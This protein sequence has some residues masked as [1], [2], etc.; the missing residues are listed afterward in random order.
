MLFAGTLYSDGGIYRKAKEDLSK[1]FGPLALESAPFRWEHSD[2]YEQELG[3]PLTRRFIFFERAIPPDALA[4][5]KLFT[6]ELETRYSEAGKRRI[7][8]DPGYLTLAKVVLAS[9]KN[10]SHRVYLRDGIYAEV[11]LMY[12]RG[13]GFRPNMNTYM[14]FKSN[15]CLELFATARDALK[16]RLGG[17]EDIEKGLE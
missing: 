7:N 15:E 12:H 6:N 14:D 13:V 4:D 17:L 5:I 2:Y 8:L 11:T 1:R 10:Y 9:T 16:R 3:S